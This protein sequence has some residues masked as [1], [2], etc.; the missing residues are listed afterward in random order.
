[1]PREGKITFMHIEIIPTLVHQLRETM[2]GANG[3]TWIVDHKSD[4]GVF[5]VIDAISAEQ[6]LRPI[7]PG[8]RSIA[9]HVKHLQFSLALTHLRMQGQDPKADWLSSFDLPDA[10]ADGW[11]QLKRDLRKSFDDVLTVV[12]EQA[13]VPLA[14]WPPIYVVGLVA[15]IAHNAYHLGAI[16]QIAIAT[17]EAGN[18]K[19]E[20]RNPK[21]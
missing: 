11:E 21:Q 7:A 2:E 10:S 19:S 6:A 16:K 18:P 4:A 20:A 15:M 14:G 13:K 17:R 9:E 5:G 1:M 8:N 12:T 3:P